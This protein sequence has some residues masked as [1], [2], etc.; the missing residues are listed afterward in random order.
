MNT[1]KKTLTF[2]IIGCGRIGINL[3][4]FL[5]S[6]QFHAKGFASKNFKSAKK[7]CKVIKQGKAFKNPCDAAKDCDLI[8]I[9]TP[10]NLIEKLCHDLAKQNAF[11]KD[12]IV[13]HLSGAL[14]SK[15]LMS[16][17]KNKAYIGSI[18]PLQSFPAYKSSKKSLFKGINISIEGDK[19]AVIIG[20]KIA[21][22]LGA[23]PFIISSKAKTLYHAS[24][25]VASNYLV[26][27]QDFALNMMKKSGLSEKDAYKLLEP[28]INGTLSNIKEKGCIKA[29][30]G[31]VLRYDIDII[32]Q[33]LQEIDKN[34]KHFSKLYRLLGLYTLDLAKK[35]N[36]IS[37]KKEKIK[38]I[39]LK[40][41]L[42]QK[43]IIKY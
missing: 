34:F 41:L 38:A 37:K 42:Q 10:D 15:I 5:S 12:S 25:V 19:K 6:H 9:T 11:S 40:N 18:H 14:D 20:K 30:T 31:P 32:K 2:C 39:K 17:K 33:H 7:A 27:L 21:H 3:A 35:N 29:L 4:V 8:F 43:T 13:F 26:T 23:K 24:A 1:N 36:K 28:L 16:A 22:T